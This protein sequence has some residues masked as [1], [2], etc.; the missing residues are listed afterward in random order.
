[1]AFNDI[2]AAMYDREDEIHTV[3]LIIPEEL[4]TNM[5]DRTKTDV[6]SPESPILCKIYAV[7]HKIMHFLCSI[8]AFLN[9]KPYFC[10]RKNKIQ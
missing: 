7:L 9:K 3:V 5:A 1:L 10:S 4:E 6:L 8:F 2:A